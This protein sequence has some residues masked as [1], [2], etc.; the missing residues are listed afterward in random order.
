MSA[1]NQEAQT[2]SRISMAELSPLSRDCRDISLQK[3]HARGEKIPEHH[4]SLSFV[5]P[6]D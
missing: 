6:T 2:H 1:S 5:P 4:N 3:T